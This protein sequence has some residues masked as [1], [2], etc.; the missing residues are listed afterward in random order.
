VG[1]DR[2]ETRRRYTVVEA[3]N[4]LGITVEAVRGRIKRGTLAHEKDEHGT[5]YVLLD[6]DE[7]RAVEDPTSDQTPA[8]ALIVERLDSQV[9]D[10]HD[11]VAYLR[12]LLNERNEADRENRRTI[13]ALTSRIPELPPG[14]EAPRESPQAP[15]E[16]AQEGTRVQ[17]QDESGEPQEKGPG[18]TYRLLVVALMVLL[19]LSFAALGYFGVLLFGG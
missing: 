17:S 9:R 5:V 6:V 19:V 7:T 10:L 3:A 16:G 18:L 1:E 13:A 4:I 14:Q 11:E 15:Q 8:Q 12:Q 2:S